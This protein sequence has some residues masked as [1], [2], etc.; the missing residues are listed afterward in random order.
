[1]VLDAKPGT[2]DSTVHLS[3]G[4]LTTV[5][6]YGKGLHCH[7]LVIAYSILGLFVAIGIYPSDVELIEID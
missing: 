3:R 4:G 2:V 7:Q 6:P 1:M 5:N